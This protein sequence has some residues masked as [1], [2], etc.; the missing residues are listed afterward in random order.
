[1]EYKYSLTSYFLHELG[2][3]LSDDTIAFKNEE[4]M[5]NNKFNDSE[6]INREIDKIKDKYNKYDKYLD[7]NNKNIKEI[8]VCIDLL[9]GIE[10][11]FKT[12]FI[13]VASSILENENINKIIDCDTDNFDDTLKESDKIFKR[14]IKD[15]LNKICK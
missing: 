5:F 6:R 9:L 1:M 14:V 8:I 7:I 3:N 12:N 2:S 10:I 13:L 15:Y 11:S 4:E